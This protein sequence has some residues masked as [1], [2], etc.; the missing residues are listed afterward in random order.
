MQF[1]CEFN[2]NMREYNKISHNHIGDI[3]IQIK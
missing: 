1:Q 3:M 2:V